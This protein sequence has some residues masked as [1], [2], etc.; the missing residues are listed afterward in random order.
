[1]TPDT[2]EEKQTSSQLKTGR[3]KASVARVMI[4]AGTGK[5]TVN[6]R[7]YMEYFPRTFLQIFVRE[8]FEV[9][10]PKGK[11]DTVARVNGG[12]IAGQAGAL[13][14]GMARALLADDLNR[15]LPLR[16]AGFLTRDSRTKERKKYGQKGARKRFQWTKR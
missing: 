14:H 2:K 3:R 12:G 11:L 6:G 15:R 9:T 4:K 1:M 16:Q 10:Q 7:D 8:P 5:I 13:R